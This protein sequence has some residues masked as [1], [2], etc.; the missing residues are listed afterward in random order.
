MFGRLGANFSTLGIGGSGN[1]YNPLAPALTVSPALTPAGPS[2]S[3]TLLTTTNGTWTNTPTFAYRWFRGATVISGETANTYTTVVGDEG[4]AVYA[5][6]A[7]TANGVTRRANSNAHSVTA[8]VTA[9]T[10]TS[11]ATANNTENSVLAHALTANESVTWSIIG[12]ADLARFELS[13]STLRWL[14]D[15]TKNF[16]VPDDAD[17]NNTYVVTVRATDTALNTT[18]QTITVT[19]T[20]L[21][22]G[23]ADALLIFDNGG[24]TFLNLGMI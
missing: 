8:D 9:P 14:S 1:V 17:V 16:E 21:G 24:V 7:A 4:F 10:I 11:A 15:G 18:N 2:A 20:D 5:E 23:G 22:E 6:V 13:G 12:G 19:V 3:G